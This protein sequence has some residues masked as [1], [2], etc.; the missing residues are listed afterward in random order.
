LD[1]RSSY[2]KHQ[3]KRCSELQ[4]NNSKTFSVNKFYPTW[5]GSAYSLLTIYKL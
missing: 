4:V 3:L 5:V 2:Q 1:T